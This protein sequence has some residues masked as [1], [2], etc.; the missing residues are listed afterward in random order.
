MN[1]SSGLPQIHITI[2]Y[3]LFPLRMAG[4]VGRTVK[5]LSI[6]VIVNPSDK[7]DWVGGEPA[8]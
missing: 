8:T 6:N 5:T 3:F 4:F 7:M 2:Y 1:L